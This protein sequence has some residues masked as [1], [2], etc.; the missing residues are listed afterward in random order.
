MA[1]SPDAGDVASVTSDA[2]WRQPMGVVKRVAPRA[3]AASV[4]SWVVVGVVVLLCAG[5]IVLVW[6]EGLL[7][8]GARSD[9][10]VVAAVLSLTGALVAASLTFVGVL[11]KHSLDTRNL[12]LAE[13][14]EARLK[15]ETSIS[16]VQLLTLE[17][18]KEAPPPRQAGSLFVLASLGQLEFALALL[19]EIWPRGG[20]SVHAAN[21]VVDRA[22]ASQDPKLQMVGAQMLVANA[23]AISET[24]DDFELPQST[25]L[26]W[27]T[28]A[29]YFTRGYLL[30]AILR[31]ATSRHLDE[32]TP[33]ILNF[34]VVQLNQV[35]KLDP[36]PEY[37]GG[38]ALALDAILGSGLY[39]DPLVDLYLPDG[40]L[41]VGTLRSEIQTTL[42]DARGASSAVVI[43]LV[44]LLVRSPEPSVDPD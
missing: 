13:E 15:L 28:S 2:S 16:A 43:E 24:P 36:H 31:A 3:R 10:Q 11:L 30:E 35:R 9:A 44:E 37:Q 12:R 20:I 25:N 27:P 22:L 17:D 29:H 21:W 40:K 39:D 14:T 33:G 38:A 6:Q 32:W 18:G 1:A 8:V 41:R 34:L 19:D 23:G 4:W 26:D 42:P 7:D 5:L